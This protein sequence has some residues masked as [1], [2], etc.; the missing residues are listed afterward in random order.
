MSFVATA[1]RGSASGRQKEKREKGP[2]GRYQAQEK[3]AKKGGEGENP[4][5]GPTNGGPQAKKKRKGKKGG[6]KKGKKGN[7]GKKIF[8]F[9]RERKEK[10]N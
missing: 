9:R 1:P 6:G 3:R 2:V 5:S 8:F 7:T 4:G 10:K